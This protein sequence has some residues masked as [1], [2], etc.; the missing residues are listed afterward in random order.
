MKYTFP[1]SWLHQ[2][3]ERIPVVVAKFIV[4]VTEGLVTVEERNI[5]RSPIWELETE[6]ET[7][8]K[9]LKTLERRY[10]FRDL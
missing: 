6:D 9:L 10:R 1:E 5:G 7:A 4:C 3:T 8:A 2:E